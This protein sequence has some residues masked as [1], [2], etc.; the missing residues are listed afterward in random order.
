VLGYNFPGEVWYADAYKLMDSKGMKPDVE[1]RASHGIFHRAAHVLSFHPGRHTAPPPPADAPLS[2]NP[3]VKPDT[4]TPTSAAPDTS[5]SDQPA[6]PKK[7]GGFHIPF[8]GKKP[9]A[10]SAGQPAN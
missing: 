1:P 4:P 10:D 3:L 9:A 7:K 6:K 8:L 2:D 5:S